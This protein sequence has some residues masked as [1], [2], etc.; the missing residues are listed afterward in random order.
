ML[1]NRWFWACLNFCGAGLNLL[2]GISNIFMAPDKINFNL[3]VFC[4]CASV[5][6]WAY[7]DETKK[8]IEILRRGK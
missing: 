3:M 2:I 6:W 1:T 5:Q 4:F 7:P 8:I